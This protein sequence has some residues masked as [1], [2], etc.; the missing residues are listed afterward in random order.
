MFSNHSHKSWPVTFDIV[1]FHEFSAC[2]CFL[3]R[4]IS[5]TGARSHGCVGV[6][7]KSASSC[8]R[9]VLYL[10]VSKLIRRS[11][12]ISGSAGA[13]AVVQPFQAL[14]GLG[15][16]SVGSFYAFA[17]MSRFAWASVAAVPTSSSSSPCNE[18]FFADLVYSS[19]FFFSHSHFFAVVLVAYS[20]PSAPTPRGVEGI[21]FSLLALPEPA[22]PPPFFTFPFIRGTPVRAASTCALLE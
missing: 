6:P 1:A 18:F 11:V 17:S 19:H 10:F 16:A 3:S 7:W 8:G 12:S 22:L 20:V 9:M 2:A 13:A 15:G 4:W 14:F 5:T 21:G